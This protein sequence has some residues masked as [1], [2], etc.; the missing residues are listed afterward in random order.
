MSKGW[1]VPEHTASCDVAPPQRHPTLCTYE[2]EPSEVVSLAQRLLLSVRA[3]DGKEFGGYN[4]TTILCIERVRAGQRRKE[5]RTDHALE[6][7]QVK[8]SVQCTYKGPL[9]DFSARRACPVDE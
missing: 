7:V 6:T 9:H 3:F 5:T 2:V 1:N 8:Y 4:V